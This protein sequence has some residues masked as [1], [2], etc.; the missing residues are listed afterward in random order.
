MGVFADAIS[1]YAQPLL[2]QSDGSREGLQKALNLS[3]LCYNI[4]TRPEPERAKLISQ[5]KDDLGMSEEDLEELR[6][7]VIQ[8]MLVRYD[9]MFP[10][11]KQ[12]PA[13]NVPRTEPSNRPSAFTLDSLAKSDEPLPYAP[14]PCNSGKKYKFCCKQ[15]GR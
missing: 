12:F 7:S 1:A 13:F 3:A 4:G 10:K 5:L 11:G 14:C 15:K 9:K 6:S 2:E 8:P